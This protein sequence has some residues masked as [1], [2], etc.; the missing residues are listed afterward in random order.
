MSFLYDDE[1]A[2]RRQEARRAA[3]RRGTEH[4]Q[5]P[6]GRWFQRATQAWIEGREAPAAP[7]RPAGPAQSRTERDERRAAG[8]IFSL[9]DEQI[10]DAQAEHRLRRRRADQQVAERD[11][12]WSVLRDSEGSD[13]ADQWM[14]GGDA[15]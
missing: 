2:E 12:L 10:A 5:S 15:A 8:F 13:Y 3:L 9:R 11:H 1:E 6:T 14:N 4:A 7:P